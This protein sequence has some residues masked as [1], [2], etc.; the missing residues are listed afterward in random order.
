MTSSMR[1]QCL[2]RGCSHDVLL[3]VGRQRMVLVIFFVF[4]VVCSD[5]NAGGRDK[6]HSAQGVRQGSMEF[7]V[8]DV[9]VGQV[10][11]QSFW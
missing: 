4:F 6:C 7:S 2:G 11:S 1:F 3:S 10:S 9:S 5:N 8:T